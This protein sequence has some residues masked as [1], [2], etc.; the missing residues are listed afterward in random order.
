[1]TDKLSEIF[2]LGHGVSQG[3]ENYFLFGGNSNSVQVEPW[4]RSG[5][6]GTRSDPA[7]EHPGTESGNLRDDSLDVKTGNRFTR[8]L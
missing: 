4:V 5:L 6:I 3:L 8:T 7:I 1:M 2:L